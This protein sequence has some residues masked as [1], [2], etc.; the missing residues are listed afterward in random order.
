MQDILV[1]GSLNPG[2]KAGRR[3]RSSRSERSEAVNEVYFFALSQTG[4]SIGNVF[5]KRVMHVELRAGEYD[6]LLSAPCST[7][8]SHTPG[9][10]EIS[11]TRP[12]LREPPILGGSSTKNPCAARCVVVHAELD[13]APYVKSEAGFRV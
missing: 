7:C 12:G 11:P 5:E 13:P 9:L 2:E 1:S 3:A 8:I 4:L 6:L 10:K